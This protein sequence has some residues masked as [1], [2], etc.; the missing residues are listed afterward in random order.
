M[1]RAASGSVVPLLLASASPRRRE[2]LGLIGVRFVVVVSRFDESALLSEATDPVS[3]VQ[4]AARGKAEDVAVRRAG[5]VLG[6]DTDV[7]G[8]EG[9]ILGKPA[10]ADEAKKMLRSLSGRTHSVYSGIALLRSEAGRVVQRE[11]VIVETRV[12]FAELPQSAIEAYVATG[13]PIDKAGA[14]AIQG[15]ALPFVSKIEGDL[16]SVIGLP[17]AALCTMLPRFGVALWN[18]ASSL[19]NEGI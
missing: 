4:A 2:L 5:V 17:L 7:V 15:G 11:E 6:V 13:E 14:Y 10:N 8:P 1:L 3:Y 12:T 9:R 16:A 19:S 18:A